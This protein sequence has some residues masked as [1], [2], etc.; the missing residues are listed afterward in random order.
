MNTYCV[1]TNSLLYLTLKSSE[2]FE[3]LHFAIKQYNDLKSN[4]PD[5][6]DYNIVNVLNVYGYF[7]I[8]ENRI[9]EAIEIFKLN[10]ALYPKSWNTY[11][12][13]GEAYLKSGNK[14]LA[15]KNYKKS[16]ELNPSRTKTLDVIKQLQEKE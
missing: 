9:E 10:V 13:L 7:L 14:E 1:Q 16:L 8:S 2:C 3:D 6:Y 11:D 5:S 4:N 12:S 15:I